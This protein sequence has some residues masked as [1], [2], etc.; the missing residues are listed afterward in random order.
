E[1]GY[2]SIT[3]EPDGPPARFGLSIVDLM[4]GLTA[5]FGLACAIIGARATGKGTDVDTSLFDTGLHN[6]GYLATWYLNSGHNQGR[7][8]MGAHPSLVP[9]QLYPTAD[10]H[11]FI[12]CNKDVFWPVLAD[13][14]G[15]PEWGTDPRFARFAD[16]LANREE[17][18]TLLI[19]EFTQRPTADWLAH[20]QGDVPCAPVLDIQGAL[21]NP[22]V[23]QSDRISDFDGPAP[24][25]M[26]S[27]PLRVPGE[28]LPHKAAPELGSDTDRLLHELGFDSSAISELRARGV[29]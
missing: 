9:S 4:A 10:G 5:A 2:L 11:I 13:K 24:L 20:L 3:G 18:N 16:R 29:V 28:E 23:A 17:L 21:E 1:A 19:A 12:M 8:P 22:F 7:E 25:R 15:H 27:S 6:V 26:L 14:L